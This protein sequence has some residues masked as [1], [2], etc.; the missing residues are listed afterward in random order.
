SWDDY[1]QRVYKAR[2]A[3]SQNTAGNALLNSYYKALTNKDAPAN[4]QFSTSLINDIDSFQGVLGT[5]LA[6]QM[7]SALRMGLA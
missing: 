2:G 4:L 7:A 6:I 1:V 3:V 5:K